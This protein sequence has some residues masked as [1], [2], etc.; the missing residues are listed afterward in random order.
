MIREVIEVLKAVPN[1]RGRGVFYWEP[2]GA[3]NWSG[4]RLSAWGKDGRPTKALS[5]FMD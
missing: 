4:Y 3:A 1:N 2:Q 5:A